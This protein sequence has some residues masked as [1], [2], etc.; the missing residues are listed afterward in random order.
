MRRLMLLLATGFFCLSANAQTDTLAVVTDTIA[1]AKGDTIRIGNIL[2][3]KRDG[4]KGKDGKGTIEIGRTQKKK[5]SR[6]TTNWWIIDLGLSNYID[7]TDYATV[8]SYLVDRPGYPALDENDFKLRAGKS[9]NVN[10]WFFMQRMA[11]IK[12]NVNLKYGLG[13]EL[14]NYRFKSAITFRENGEIP[15]SGGLQTNAPFVFRDSI[16]FKK[17]KLAADYLTIPVMLNFRTTPSNGKKGVGISFGVSGGYLYSQRNKQKSEERGKQK[18]KG[19]YDLNRFKFSYLGEV[20]LG[21]V[22]LYGSYSPKSIF[23]NNMDFRP[24]TLG[25]RLGRL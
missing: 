23:D 21:P 6:F 22:Q 24:Y 15:Y 25:L 14:N 20:N 12:Q 3:I 1:P 16:S 2:V 8:G 13:L 11:L 18:G 5:S 10:I 4:K 7:K 9:V 17:N 19:D